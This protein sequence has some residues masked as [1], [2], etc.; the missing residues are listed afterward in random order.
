MSKT[1][2]AIFSAFFPDNIAV[3]AKQKSFNS[4]GYLYGYSQPSG[5]G[6]IDLS[7]PNYESMTREEICRNFSD[8]FIQ[9]NLI[10]TPFYPNF[11]P[12]KTECIKVIRAPSRTHLINLDFRTKSFEIE[13]DNHGGCTYDY[14]EI[15]NGPY[16]FSPLIGRFCGD[17]V[18]P[19]VIADS[20]AMWVYFR[21]DANLQYSG[22]QADYSY[23]IS[24]ESKQIYLHL[25]SG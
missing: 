7:T 15:R 9:P 12:P 8:G 23:S 6:L 10:S 25:C 20:G 11:Y 18:P 21:T 14:I 24:K 1:R 13:M 5:N 4:W 19:R 22:F 17:K 3:A 2:L 16:G